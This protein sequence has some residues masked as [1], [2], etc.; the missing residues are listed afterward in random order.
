MSVA[1]MPRCVA[2]SKLP[3]TTRWNTARNSSSEAGRKNQTLGGGGHTGRRRPL[4]TQP[5][6]D[7]GQSGRL[8]RLA[9]PGH[10][11]C[12]G[13]I[14]VLPGGRHDQHILRLRRE[15][16]CA[17]RDKSSAASAAR[18]GTSAS[19][20]RKSSASGRSLSSRPHHRARATILEP[21]TANQLHSGRSRPAAT[22]SRSESASTNP[23]GSFIANPTGSSSSARVAGRISKIASLHDASID[24]RFRN[25]DRPCR[26]R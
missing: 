7:L 3:T 6:D 5:L 11:F 1:A 12:D 17:P 26:Q 9:T 23:T 20:C 24:D 14:R 25:R 18:S 8:G 22:S 19:T 16:R 21:S 10:G 2:T 13:G 15:T 4:E